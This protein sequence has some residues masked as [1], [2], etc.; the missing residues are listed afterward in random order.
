MSLRIGVPA[1]PPADPSP[2]EV[3]ALKTRTSPAGQAAAEALAALEW[4]QAA[5]AERCFWKYC[6][7]FDSTPAGNIGPVA[8]ALMAQEMSLHTAF[9]DTRPQTGAVVHLHSSHSVAWS[10]TP[11]VDPENA[12]PVSYAYGLEKALLPT[13]SC[14]SF[15]RCR[16]TLLW[17]ATSWCNH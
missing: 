10:M 6:S 3:I 11:A 4:L 13:C 9:Y 7:T 14:G 16:R 8:E 2:Y 1:G 17:H 15:L 5:G 12:L